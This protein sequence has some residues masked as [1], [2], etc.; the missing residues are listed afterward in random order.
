MPR[1]VAAKW[2]GRPT[3]SRL[4]RIL[5]RLLPVAVVIALLTVVPAA[6]RADP[7][8]GLT[9]I[10]IATE[11]LDGPSCGGT[12]VVTAT[13]TTDGRAGTIRYRWLRN[14][15]TPSADLLQPVRTGEFRADLALSWSFTGHGTMHA[16]ATVEVLTPRA[17]TATAAFD[18]TCRP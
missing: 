3:P 4:R 17:L 8:L 15:G 10:A 2:H 7:P 6:C 12:A 13:V 14:D 16:T 9:G 11:P 5:R 18:Y 1:A